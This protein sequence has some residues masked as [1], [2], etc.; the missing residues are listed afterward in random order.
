MRCIIIAI[1]LI[2]S[3]T[4]KKEHLTL[5]TGN[6]TF[7]ERY[8]PECERFIESQKKCEGEGCFNSAA[9]EIVGV[10]TAIADTHAVYAWCWMQQFKKV[11]KL[12][13][14]SKG[15]FT[16]VLFKVLVSGRSYSVVDVFLPDPEAPLKEQLTER[17]FPDVLIKSY[18]VNQRNDVE[19]ERVRVLAEK[20]RDKYKMY[21]EKAYVPEVKEET[22]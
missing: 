8:A 18:F 3:C 4:S 22:E 9:L 20:A 12:P 7:F 1:F 16:P 11:E 5:V 17:E 2:S 14:G 21:L 10:D 15:V 13:S 6:L 19:K